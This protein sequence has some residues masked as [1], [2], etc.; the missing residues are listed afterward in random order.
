MPGSPDNSEH[1]CRPEG[2]ETTLQ[3]RKRET[4]PAHLLKQSND[5]DHRE[6]SYTDPQPICVGPTFGAGAPV[7]TVSAA[8][9][10]AK[11]KGPS[12]AMTYQIGYTR[13]LHLYELSGAHHTLGYFDGV[14]LALRWLR[15]ASQTRTDHR[16]HSLDEYIAVM[17]ASTP[18][19]KYGPADQPLQIWVFSDVGSAA[20]KLTTRVGPN[21]AL[22]E[23]RPRRAT[24]TRAGALT[25]RSVF[26]DEEAAACRRPAKA[27]S[28]GLIPVGRTDAT[29][30]QGAT[31]DYARAS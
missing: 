30:G 24:C 5:D 29:D 16:R 27:I 28:A 17:E 6:Q 11:P 1:Q 26:F 25:P 4:A 13:Q 15:S 23:P 21:W 31:V 9:T 12:S 20:P 7:A 2:I 19:R 10:A 22:R 8:A 14:N 3:P 18:S